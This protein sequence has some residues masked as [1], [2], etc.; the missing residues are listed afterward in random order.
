MGAAA[1]W[2]LACAMPA[3]ASTVAGTVTQLSG[4]MTA[5][6]ADGVVRPL[7]L[8]SEVASGEL[9]TTAKDSYAIVKFIDDSEIVLKPVTVLAIDHFVFEH[10]KPSGDS[11]GL[12]L[13]R[14]GMRSVT[15]LLG[16][17]N[18][19]K[20]TL[21]TPSATI[22]IRGTTFFLE[23]LTGSADGAAASALDPGLHV[24]VSDG[25]ISLTN[26]AGFFQYDPGQ[27]GYIKD[28]KTKPAKMFANPGMRFDLPAEFGASGLPDK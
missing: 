20:F 7:A 21:H 14:G 8:K 18:K 11:A 5:S 26:Q 9:L 12:R 25:G 10:G 15:G 22:G 27:Y 2:A 19:E 1:A 23:Y 24:Y 28:D 6:R 16:K 4:A 17:R 13:L 3:L